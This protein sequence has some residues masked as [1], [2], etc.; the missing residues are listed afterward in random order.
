MKEDIL[1]FKK[2][3]PPS[4]YEMFDNL[5]ISVTGYQ[6][7]I[8]DD[9][10]KNKILKLYFENY[11]VI[12]VKG[13]IKYISKPI[14]FAKEINEDSVEISIVEPH[15]NKKTPDGV[16]MLILQ[17]F[18]G[19]NGKI[20]GYCDSLS[21]N[22]SVISSIMAASIGRNVIFNEVFS[23]SVNQLFQAEIESAGCS[24]LKGEL[25][26]NSLSEKN[27][28]ISIAIHNSIH[29]IE[30]NLKKIILLS[31]HWFEQALRASFESSQSDSFLKF[32]VAL[33]VLAMPDTSDIRPIKEII[34]CIYNLTN[35]EASKKFKIGQIYGLRCKI[36]HD[37]MTE[38]ANYENTMYLEAL[39]IDIL[40][41]R[42][43]LQSKKK[44]EHLISL[45]VYDFRKAIGN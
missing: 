16:Y 42:L 15:K 1:Q 40:F 3:I 10:F 2:L 6:V 43:G 21:K 20:V 41:Y 30:N 14:L 31:L 8:R 34:S 39:Y 35:D 45:P 25:N 22:K 36:V 24:I 12:F 26:E 18:D 37:G 29:S 44:L 4:W 5:F 23:Y 13:N 11:M 32:W 27:L 7:F 9:F 33:E 28:E 38:V 19:K 17:P